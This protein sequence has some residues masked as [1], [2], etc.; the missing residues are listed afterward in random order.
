MQLLFPLFFFVLALIAFGLN[1]L[2]IMQLIPI[3]ITLP[4]LFI[5]IY[6]TIYSLFNQ[7]TYRRRRVR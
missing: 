6:L 1:I 5:A 7:N 2:G 4:I 3:Y